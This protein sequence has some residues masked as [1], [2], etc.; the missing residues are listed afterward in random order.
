LPL[1]YLN[2][3][4]IDAAPVIPG[5][6]FRGNLLQRAPDIDSEPAVSDKELTCLAKAVY[7]EARGE[8]ERG[9]TAVAK[10][11]LNRVESEKYPDTICGVVY[12]NAERRNACQF[13]FAC[14]GVPDVAKEQKAWQRAQSI[15]VET[16]QGRN[17]PGPVLTATHYHA[18]YVHPYWANK[19]ERLS[20]IGSHIFYRG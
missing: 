10:V 18:D 9:Q 8:P 3:P 12:Q 13:S 17:V 15:A 11:I 14:D 6:P 19:L 20:K 7:F 5:L 16:L 4:E 2:P 1:P